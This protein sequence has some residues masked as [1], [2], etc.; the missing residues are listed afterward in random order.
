MKYEKYINK[1]VLILLPLSYIFFV[2]NI[3]RLTNIENVLRLVI[4]SFS[5]IVNIILVINFINLKLLKKKTKYILLSIITILSIIY[6][7]SGTFIFKSFSYLSKIQKQYVTY[8]TILISKKDNFNKVAITDNKNDAEGNVLPLMYLKKKNK[9][10]K[11]EKYKNYDDMIKSL[12]KI[13]ALFISKENLDHYSKELTNYKVVDKYK[14]KIKNVDYIETK[15]VDLNNPFTFLIIGIDS[16]YDGIKTNSSFNGDALMVVTFNPK[17]LNTTIFSIPRD[18]YVKIGCTGNE[19]KINSATGYGTKCMIDTVEELIGLDIDYYAKINFKGVVSLVDA[20][21]GIEVNV[22]EPDYPKHYC[23]DNSDR[24]GKG[25]CLTPG[26]NTLD[27]EKSLALT[28][29]RKAFA[30]GDFKRVQNQQLVLEATLNKMKGVRNVNTFFKILDTISHNLETNMSTKEILS[31]YNISKNILTKDTTLNVEKSYLSGYSLMVNRAYTYQPYQGS[32]DE[33]ID[34]MKY[35]LE[36]KNPTLIKEV[37]FNK[38]KPYEQ[39]VAGK[40]EYNEDKREIIINLVGKNINY[41]K[42]WLSSRGINVVTNNVKN[43]TCKNNEVIKQSVKQGRL[44][45]DISSIVLDVC[46]ED[47]TVDRNKE[48]QNKPNNTIKEEKP[49]VDETLD[50]EETEI[51]EDF[52]E[53]ENEDTLE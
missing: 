4:L 29:I 12:D 31:L 46:E 41:A 11:V 19:N 25:I 53:E 43:K 10:F 2:Y 47:K 8:E 20:I 3:L 37:S 5:L 1:A 14:K 40:G 27:G 7:I 23:V 32:L 36:L 33:I 50:E 13:D 30:L 48:N 16:K 45:A 15:N 52:V 24:K 44:I 51:E 34:M 42:N 6:I 21:N 22:P 38:E 17:N 35:N 18:T 28:R 9:T 26:L 49:I 39:I